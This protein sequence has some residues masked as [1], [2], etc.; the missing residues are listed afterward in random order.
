MRHGP[1]LALIWLR[2]LWMAIGEEPPLL[3]L[4]PPDDF[5]GSDSSS[6]LLSLHIKKTDGL[7]EQMLARG[8]VLPAEVTKLFTTTQ[9]NQ[10]SARLELYAGERPFCEGNRFL[11]ML[12]LAPLPM[13]SYR[14]FVQLEVTLLVDSGAIVCRAA[15]VE[16]RALGEPFC[17]AE[18]R[19]EIGL[20]GPPPACSPYSEVTLFSHALTKHLP[21]LLP[22]RSVRLGGRDVIIRQHQRRE[23]ERIGTGGVLWEA[24]IVLADFVGRNGEQLA[25]AGKKVL[26]LGAGTGL[27][28]IALAHAGA[29]VTATDGNLR[30]LQGAEANLKAAQPFAGSVALEVFDWNSA[31]DLAKIQRLGPW[32][33]IVGSDLVYPG[34]AGKK[35]VDSNALSPPADQTLIELLEALRN[36]QT[37][38]ILALKDRTGEL[39]RFN[40][41]LLRHGF[42]S[43]RAVPDS[44]MPE[45]RDIPQVA[46][47]HLEKTT[48]RVSNLCLAI[49]GCLWLF[50]ESIPKCKC[51]YAR[52]FTQISRC[53]RVSFITLL[54]ISLNV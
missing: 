26:E 38:M 9:D 20:G 8:S 3:A 32:D 4:L 28:A 21:V 13:P 41:T 6:L 24:A 36:D 47:L 50:V 19:G 11:G 10:A 53:E 31:E 35:C 34:N 27:V 39:E 5:A 14:S 7:C 33:A 51:N 23:Q 2:L 40:A 44:I 42:S 17:E 37:Q 43:R 1:Y 16:S 45:F 25:W 15:E 54:L 49:A 22:T 30:V 29:A 18:W 46:V 12:E 52:C 48:W